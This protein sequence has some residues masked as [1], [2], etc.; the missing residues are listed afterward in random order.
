MNY[1]AIERKSKLRT[2]NGVQKTEN[3]SM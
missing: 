3:G 1:L 2:R